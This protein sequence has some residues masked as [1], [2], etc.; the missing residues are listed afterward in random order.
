MRHRRENST[1]LNQNGWKIP[2]P[3]LLR[4]AYFDDRQKSSLIRVLA[5]VFERNYCSSERYICIFSEKSL[6]VGNSIAKCVVINV[7]DRKMTPIFFE[8]DPPEILSKETMVT[9]LPTRII[10]NDKDIT[11]YNTTMLKINRRE[12]IS[13]TPTKLYSCISPLHDWTWRNR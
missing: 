9:V 12:N 3:A 7:Y 13:E 11:M 5:M 1:I 2:G 6:I 4:S 10:S 8:C